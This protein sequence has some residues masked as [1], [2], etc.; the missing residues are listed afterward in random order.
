MGKYECLQKTV[1]HDPLCHEEG[2]EFLFVIFRGKTLLDVTKG[3]YFDLSC[4]T[5][6]QT[7]CKLLLCECYKFIRIF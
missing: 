4:A 6:C 5:V 7:Y 3:W 2:E 1:L